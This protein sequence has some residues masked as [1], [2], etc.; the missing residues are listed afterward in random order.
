MHSS[1]ERNSGVSNVFLDTRCTALKRGICTKPVCHPPQE[2]L[3]ALAASMKKNLMNGV[4]AF[5]RQKWSVI[6]IDSASINDVISRIK[7]RERA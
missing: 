1:P 6:R 5:D 7:W 4:G 3:E 2:S